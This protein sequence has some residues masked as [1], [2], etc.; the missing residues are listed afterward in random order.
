MFLVLTTNMAACHV[1]ANQEF[2][3]SLTW[4]IMLH[5]LMKGLLGTNLSQ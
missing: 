5:L 4:T 3:T 1:A 2:S